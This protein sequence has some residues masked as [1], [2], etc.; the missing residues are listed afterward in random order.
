MSSSSSLIIIILIIIISNHLSLYYIDFYNQCQSD[1]YKKCSMEK[2]L[3]THDG[4]AISAHYFVSRLMS[5]YQFDFSMYYDKKL[6]QLYMS[7]DGMLLYFTVTYL[8]I[9]P[10]YISVYLSI[11]S[12]YH[13]Y[14]C[15]Y[16]WA[17]GHLLIYP[18]IFHLRIQLYLPH[19]SIHLSVTSIYLSI[20]QSHLSIISIHHY[21]LLLILYFYWLICVSLTVLLLNDAKTFGIIM[22]CRWP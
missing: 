12:I 6:R 15:E 1:R 13:I 2:A 21:S 18:S 9:T 8:S 5:E 17:N 4:S 3:W 11:I 10:I 16:T 22:L 19:I 7:F 14:L 20:Y